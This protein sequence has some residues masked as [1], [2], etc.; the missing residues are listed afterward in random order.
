MYF[1]IIGNNCRCKSQWQYIIH[2]PLLLSIL[3]YSILYFYNMLFYRRGS[4]DLITVMLQ[5]YFTRMLALTDSDISQHFIGMLFLSMGF[6]RLKAVRLPICNFGAS[7][8]GR[9]TILRRSGCALA[10]SNSESG[11]GLQCAPSIGG[12]GEWEFWLLTYVHH[13]P[14]FSLCISI[15][16]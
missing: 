3:L 14:Y 8:T 6:A 15:C 16:Q 11:F 13:L 2:D 4:E 5:S 9:S 10:L 1:W 7:I 12:D